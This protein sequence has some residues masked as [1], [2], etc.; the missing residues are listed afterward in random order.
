[1]VREEVDSVGDLLLVAGIVESIQTCGDAR[2][3]RLRAMS[4][5]VCQHCGYNLAGID[6]AQ[7]DAMCPE[8]GKTGLPSPRPRPAWVRFVWTVP[9]VLS[10]LAVVTSYQMTAA[11][12]DGWA[13]IGM[14]TAFGPGLGALAGLLSFPVMW[15]A[16]ATYPRRVRRVWVAGLIALG[17]ALAIAA[18]AAGAAALAALIATFSHP[19]TSGT[20]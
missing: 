15:T 2:S 4:D 3:D 10:F 1:M 19:A 9:L 5:R 17:V 20:C 7:G 13:Q 8:C 6:S 18:V 12:T 14:F 16:W 11:I